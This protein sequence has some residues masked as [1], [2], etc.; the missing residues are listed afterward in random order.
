MWW[1]ATTDR[2]PW[3][4][5]PCSSA[6]RR[7]RGPA[8]GAANGSA[9]RLGRVAR[10][11]GAAAAAGRGVARTTESSQRMWIGRSWVSRPSTSGPRRSTASSSSWAI[12]SSLRLPLVITSGRPTPRQQQVV[13]RA[14]TA[15][16][17]PSSGSPGATPSATSRAGAAGREHDRPARRRRARPRRRRRASHSAARAVEV[18]DHHRER[19]VVARLAP[20]QLGDRRGVGGVDREVVAA[21]ALDRDDPRRRAARRPRPSSASSPLG[22]RRARRASRHASCGPHTG[23]ALGWAWKRRSAGSSYSAW[24][25]GHIVN[26]AIVVAAGRRARDARSCSGARS[27]CSW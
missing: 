14:C 10:G 25:A 21:D 15:G 5:R 3:R 17:A 1:L 8:R 18:G 26:P 16:A 19:L 2:R 20:A 23:Q 11:S 6:R 7:R 12:G 27:R 13:Q 22:Q 9:Q 24:H 4:P